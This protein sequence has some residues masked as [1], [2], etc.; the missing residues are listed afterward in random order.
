MT[1]RFR[2]IRSLSALS[3]AGI[4]P[5]EQKTWRE[6]TF[7]NLKV[8]IYIIESCDREIFIIMQSDF[9]NK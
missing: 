5:K 8:T 1:P 4:L 2:I 7:P 9:E 6:K 3:T